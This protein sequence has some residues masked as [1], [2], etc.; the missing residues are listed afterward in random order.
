VCLTFVLRDLLRE[1]DLD[2]EFGLR[3]PLFFQPAVF[4]V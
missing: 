3:D 4:L 2:F 1:V